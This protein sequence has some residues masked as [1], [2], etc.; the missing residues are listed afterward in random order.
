[1]LLFKIKG[2]AKED[3]LDELGMT[4]H[5]DKPKESKIKKENQKNNVP[6]HLK[7]CGFQRSRH[8]KESKNKLDRELNTKIRVKDAESFKKLRKLS[9]L[10]KKPSENLS[11][12]GGYSKSSVRKYK[13]KS[14]KLRNKK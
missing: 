1:M 3:I 6:P 11:K 8:K 9:K 7:R 12:N 4:E 10:L 14:K 13:K 5:S 2:K